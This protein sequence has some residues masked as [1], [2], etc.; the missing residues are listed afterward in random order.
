MYSFII[1]IYLDKFPFLVGDDAPEVG[2]FG[3][4]SGSCLVLLIKSS[5]FSKHE[6]A[7]SSDKDG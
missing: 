6:Y 1:F 2:K 3:D 4:S 7:K 5:A